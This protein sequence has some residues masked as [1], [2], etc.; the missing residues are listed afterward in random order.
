MT[1]AQRRIAYLSDCQDRQASRTF[2]GGYRESVPSSMP[3]AGRETSVPMSQKG[4]YVV[5][6]RPFRGGW[7]L[8]RVGGPFQSQDD[9][10][11]H[12]DELRRAPEWPA[13][14]TLQQL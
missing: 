14:L 10:Q 6:R 13:D 11:N 4:W 7:S 3:L 8:A 9:A 5:Q 2:T 1:P 12:L